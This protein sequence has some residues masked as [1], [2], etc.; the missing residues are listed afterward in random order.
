[1]P[2]GGK[3]SHPDDWSRLSLGLGK[4]TSQTILCLG[5]SMED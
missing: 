1:M 2:S 4:A 5:T 3:S